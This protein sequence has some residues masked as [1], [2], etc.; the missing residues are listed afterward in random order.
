MT[1]RVHFLAAAGAVVVVLG[2]LLVPSPAAGPTGAAEGFQVYHYGSQVEGR[3]FREVFLVHQVDPGFAAPH[4][5]VEVRRNGE[6]IAVEWVAQGAQVAAGDTFS[7]VQEAFDQKEMLTA[8]VGGALVMECAYGGGAGISIHPDE[9][10]AM[11]LG[12]EVR[13]L[14]GTASDIEPDGHDGHA[15]HGGH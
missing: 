5:E 8:H 9:W 10:R 13:C 6:P 4:G 7:F 1:E 14:L 12:H 2:A 15:E 11:G 3:A